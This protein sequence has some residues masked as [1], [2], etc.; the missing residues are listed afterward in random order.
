MYN[1]GNLFF[2]TL[3]ELTTSPTHWL[4]VASKQCP[5]YSLTSHASSYPL[6][7][8]VLNTCWTFDSKR[9]QCR[10][11]KATLEVLYRF[12]QRNN[13]NFSMNKLSTSISLVGPC[14]TPLEW[15]PCKH[16]NWDNIQFFLNMEIH[17]IN[18][19]YN[20]QA[21]RMEEKTSFIFP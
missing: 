21:P 12:Q 11:C 18:S 14:P 15:V 19:T 17:L 3:L 1:L 20:I 5:H 8:F 16:P 9:F 4:C 13:S 2:L 6:L 10:F 7:T